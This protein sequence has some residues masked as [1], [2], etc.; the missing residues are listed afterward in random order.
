MKAYIPEQPL[1]SYMF[2]WFQANMPANLSVSNVI[3]SRYS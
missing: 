1:Q 3:S 2:S